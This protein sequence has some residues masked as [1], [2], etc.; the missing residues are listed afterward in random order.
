MGLRR[1]NRTGEVKKW[2]VESCL[3][4]NLQG[5]CCNGSVEQTN[6]SL[7]S[8]FCCILVHSTSKTI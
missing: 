1:G 6:C 3:Q 8:S 2:E 7:H 4:R 5:K